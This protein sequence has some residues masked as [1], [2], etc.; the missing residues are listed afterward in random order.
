MN[1]KKLR[2]GR[3]QVRWR[4]PEGKQRAKNFRAK[5]QAQDLLRKLQRGEEYEARIAGRTLGEIV[6]EWK[7]RRYP[8][9]S[10][11]SQVRYDNLLRLHLKPLLKLPMRAIT[12]EVIDRWLAHMVQ[13]PDQYGKGAIRSTFKH[14][15]ALLTTL[16]NYY[17]EYHDD[18]RFVMPTK[19]RHRKDARIRNRR[20][21]AGRKDLTEAEFRDA[22]LP[23]LAKGANGPLM[24]AFA[25]VQFH[26]ALRVSE[27]AALEWEG[28]VFDH[29]RPSASRL[30]FSQHVV[31]T[32]SREKPD[33]V[34]PGFKNSGEDDILVKE[35]PMLPEVYEALSA[36]YRPG[37]HGLVFVDPKTGAFFGYRKIQY[38][39][40][41]AF[42]RAGLPY[43][44]THV[45]RH[46]GTRKTFD[47]TRGDMAV[48]A[49]HLGNR[50]R[51]SI[52]VYA[53][54]S[55]LALTEYAQSQWDRYENGEC[56][57]RAS[58]RGG[59]TLVKEK[60]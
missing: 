54:R 49:Q 48:A 37:K 30:I 32:R 2:T 44:S 21:R 29:A 39:F 38:R 34:E 28:V 10:V 40:N 22:F 3:W 43:R 8:A 25:I 56:T 17:R 52:E 4:D 20:S 9:I 1:L 6:D 7:A 33:F 46:G 42:K 23:A 14:E 18:P 31:Y 50:N 51:K 60:Q 5:E 26:D 58:A 12:P 13:N 45:M 59:L 15:L 27:I 53:Q 24:V 55:A 35:H 47:E 11:G 16:L 36:I 41:L 57:K 19:K